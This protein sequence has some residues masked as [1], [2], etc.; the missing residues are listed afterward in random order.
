MLMVTM[1]VMLG[2]GFTRVGVLM[3]TLIVLRH[4]RDGLF[5]HRVL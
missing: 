1:I 2:F 4:I 5:L 3:R